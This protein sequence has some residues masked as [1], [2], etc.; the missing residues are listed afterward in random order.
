M[1]LSPST[2]VP[3]LL[4]ASG[5]S[6]YRRLQLY[7]KDNPLGLRWRKVDVKPTGRELNNKQ[8]GVPSTVQKLATELQIKTSFALEEWR[9]F[10]IDTL[11]M[12][13]FIT[14]G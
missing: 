12:T 14:V 13:D 7:Q 1:Q 3:A 6:T 9:E 5:D 4:A 2:T 8:R 10:R 11:H